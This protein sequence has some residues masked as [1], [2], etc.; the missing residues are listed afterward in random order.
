ME[1]F[2]ILEHIGIIICSIILICLI[3]GCLFILF[4]LA[5]TL[6]IYKERLESLEKKENKK[7]IIS[8]S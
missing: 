8:N 2:G 6:G 3:G 4:Q 1:S 7:K 5:F